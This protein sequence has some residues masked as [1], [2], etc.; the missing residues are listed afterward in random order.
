[1]KLFQRRA[2][3]W[4]AWLHRLLPA[5][6]LQERSVVSL[7]VSRADGREM[8][9]IGALDGTGIEVPSASDDGEGVVYFPILQALTLQW[10]PDGRGLSFVH[11]DMLYTV[12][13]E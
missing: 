3:P 13:V 8:R 2:S 6:P 5:F 9:E 4:R 7:W 10:L 1:W 12:P 11:H